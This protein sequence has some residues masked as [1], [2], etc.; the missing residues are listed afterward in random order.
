MLLVALTL[1]MVVQA[2]GDEPIVKP[3]PFVANPAWKP[4]G[5]SLWFDPVER[6][7]VLR[8]K[9]AIREGSLEHLLC[10]KGTKEHESILA[11]DAVP[12]KIHAGLLL[13]GAEPGHPV[14]F[15][16]KFEAPTGTAI[17]M[18]A[19]WLQG[20]TLKK[21]DVKTWVKDER[22]KKP[23]TIDWVFAGSELYPPGP[24]ETEPYYAGDDGDLFTVANFPNA[25]LDLPFASSASDADR[26]YAADPATV[27]PR[28]TWVTLYLKPKLT[29]KSN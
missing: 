29:A 19:E 1:L 25:I 23:L 13:T 17:I 28:G 10:L 5:R 8:A 24:K 14:R 3:D 2:P 15:K 11:T 7:V 20:D 16:P 6:R 27:P 21:V 18:E 9:V 22:T 12:R 26:V 4:L